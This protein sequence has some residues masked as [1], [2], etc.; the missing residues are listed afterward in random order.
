MIGIFFLNFFFMKIYCVFSLET[1]HPGD[2]NE[3]TQHTISNL[4]KKI[5]LIIPNIIM[6]AALGFFSQGTLERVGNSRHKRAISVRATDVLLYLQLVA[7]ETESILTL[8]SVRVLTAANIWYA[9]L[10]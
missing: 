2:S 4:E 10:S 3:Y 9:D 1:P 5:T 6:S 8:L 7:R